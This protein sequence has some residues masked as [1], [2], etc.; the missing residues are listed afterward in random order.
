MEMKTINTK[1]MSYILATLIVITVFVTY[2]LNGDAVNLSFWFE[3]ITRS[4]TVI[5]TFLLLFSTLLWKITALQGWL[6]LV[7]NLN[8]IWEGTLESD[9]VNPET[10][11][12]TGPIKATLTI[13]Q[14]LFHVS[15]VMKTDEMTSRSIA[16]GFILDSDNQITQLAYSYISTPLQTI[17]ERSRIHYGSVLFDIEDKMMTGNYW[18][19]RK[20]TGII[21]M[22]WK[23]K[24]KKKGTSSKS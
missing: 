3:C 2:T 22:E 21:K 9:W 17:Q 6:V 11:K 16:Y 18:T 1:I 23:N 5:S 8:G 7:P 19:G 20:T 12:K 4:V 15:C 24:L 13:K 14:S 10:N